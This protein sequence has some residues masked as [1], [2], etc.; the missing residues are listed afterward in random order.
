MVAVTVDWE[1]VEFSPEGLDALDD[2]RRH[3]GAAPVTHFVS[4]AYFTKDRPDPRAVSFL[5]EAVRSGDELAVHLHLWKSLAKASGVEPKLS[6]SYVT[7]T[8]KLY[9]FGDGDRGFDTDLDV[10]SVADL[11]ALV[12]T[13]RTLLERTRLAVSRSF[14]AGGYLGTPKVLQAIRQEGYTVD[15][16]ATDPRQVE[17][18][19]DSILP[20]RVREVWPKVTASSQPFFAEEREQQ[21]LEMPIAATADDET[22]AAI[23]RLFEAAGDQLQKAPDRDVFLV[24]S[25]NQETAQDFAGRLGEAIDRARDM[26]RLSDR[27][28][29]TTV[30]KAAALARSELPPP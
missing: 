22:A 3:L 28:L 21:V 19:K 30:E 8:D 14:R 15:S 25:C 18:R 9:D 4:A 1:G 10:Y 11:R 23:T 12:R 13:S 7:G 20:R 6:P 5:T 27:L 17:P 2:L 26:D 16:S 29:F 24:V